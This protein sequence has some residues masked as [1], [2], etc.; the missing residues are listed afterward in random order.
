MYSSSSIELGRYDQSTHSPQE[1]H[2]KLRRLIRRLQR[3]PEDEVMTSTYPPAHRADSTE[4]FFSISPS[5]A[6]MFE[7]DDMAWSRP[8]SRM[9]RH[10]KQ[11]R[12]RHARQASH[13]GCAEMLD[14]ENSAWVKPPSK[15]R[16]LT[17]QS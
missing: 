4:S 9:S 1:R 11:P 14:D 10:S 8:S 2:S 12:D 6:E 3:L 7:Y 5:E 15:S 16:R 13:E 17:R